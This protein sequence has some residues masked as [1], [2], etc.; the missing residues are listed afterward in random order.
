MCSFFICQLYLNKAEG[1]EENKVLFSRKCFNCHRREISIPSP[2]YCIL[3]LQGLTTLT[4]L[5]CIQ[6][7]MP[8][9]PDQQPDYSYTPQHIFERG[10]L[11]LPFLLNSYSQCSFYISK[12]EHLSLCMLETCFEPAIKQI[13]L[14][15]FKW[16]R[17]LLNVY[18]HQTHPFLNFSSS[19]QLIA[20]TLFER[21]SPT[22][23]P[24][25]AYINSSSPDRI[26]LPL[27]SPF[28]SPFL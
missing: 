11:R 21:P 6:R 16:F 14:R 8:R 28:L 13:S 18:V 5:V 26:P 3:V 1:R 23:N 7:D 2:Q 10:S 4:S 22:I 25:A 20:Q 27:D 19:F 12:S 15:S 24:N 9:G 17:W